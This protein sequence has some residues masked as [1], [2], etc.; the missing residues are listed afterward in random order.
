MLKNAYLVWPQPKV[1][2]E[3]CPRETEFDTPGLGGRVGYG[4]IIIGEKQC[5]FS[6]LHWLC[7][8]IDSIFFSRLP[9]S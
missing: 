9:H 5:T 1:C 4:L 2:L 7:T 6:E 8:E 3:F